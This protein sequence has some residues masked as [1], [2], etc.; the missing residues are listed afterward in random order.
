MPRLSLLLRLNHVLGWLPGELARHLD[1]DAGSA[2]AAASSGSR[3]RARRAP[4]DVVAATDDDG[5]EAGA[6]GLPP[7]RTPSSSAVK[8][9]VKVL[10]SLGVK[11][12]S[13]ESHALEGVGWD[14]LAGYDHIRCVARARGSCG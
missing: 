1:P 3:A 6:G 11:L 4:S 2:A 9:P 5:A 8:D 14:N 10:T 7:L 12:Y 13:R